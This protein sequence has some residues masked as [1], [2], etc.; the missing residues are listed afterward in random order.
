MSDSTNYYVCEKH[1]W[2]NHDEAEKGR[3]PTCVRIIRLLEEISKLQ[4]QMQ[5]L[6]QRLRQLIRKEQL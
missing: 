2:T 5:N 4:E 3:C 1:R 6:Q